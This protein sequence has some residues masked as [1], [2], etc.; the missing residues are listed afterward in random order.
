MC[1]CFISM[2]YVMKNK[3]LLKK[4]PSDDEVVMCLIH[5]CKVLLCLVVS[6]RGHRIG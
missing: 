6:T 1:V 4:T 5:L 2:C 3:I